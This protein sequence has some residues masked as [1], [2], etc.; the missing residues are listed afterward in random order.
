MQVDNETNLPRYEWCV[1]YIDTMSN[2]QNYQ[3]NIP[4]AQ[5]KDLADLSREA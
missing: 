1:F 4:T 2:S 5:I 3:P